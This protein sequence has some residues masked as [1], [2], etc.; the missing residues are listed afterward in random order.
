MVRALVVDF[1]GVVVRRSEFFKQ[2]AWPHVFTEYGDAYLPHFKRA[3]E[4]FGAGRG[5]DRF[6]I[7]RETYRGLGVSEA[8]LPAKV[9]DGAERFDSYVQAKIKE[10]GADPEVIAALEGVA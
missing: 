7:L 1:D 6:D 9:A 4:Q 2:E 8:E 3:E 5:G 10:A